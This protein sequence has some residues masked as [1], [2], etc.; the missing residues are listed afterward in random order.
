MGGKSSP[1]QERCKDV[2][3][4]CT[5]TVVTMTFCFKG[6]G[7]VILTGHRYNLSKTIYYIFYLYINSKSLLHQR[8]VS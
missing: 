1:L 8:V 7:I 4:F 6:I 5:S 3:T 2:R